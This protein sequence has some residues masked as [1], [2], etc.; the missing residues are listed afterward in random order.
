ML[1]D[2]G[3]LTKK[4]V[5]EKLTEGDILLFSKEE[6]ETLPDEVEEEAM[7]PNELLKTGRN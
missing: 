5:A 4:Q 3:I 2:R 1:F 6:L 7:N